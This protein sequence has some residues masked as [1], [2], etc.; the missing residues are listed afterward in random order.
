MGG[1]QLE[2]RLS[3]PSPT[4]A[5]SDVDT[6]AP[7]SDEFP[8]ELRGILQI[9]IDQNDSV[10]HGMLEASRQRFPVAEISGES[11]NPDR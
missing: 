2:S 5:V 11:D 10:A 6:G 9:S 3:R 8:N 7:T 1:E 4:N